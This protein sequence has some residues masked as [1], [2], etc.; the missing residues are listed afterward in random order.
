MTLVRFNQK[1]NPIHVMNEFFNNPF[2]DSLNSDFNTNVPAVNVIENENSFTIEL[3][4]PGFNKNDFEVSID[5]D[6][7]TISA[8]V[9]HEHEET[10]TKFTRRE[11]SLSSFKRSFKLPK[12]INNESIKAQY[13]NGILNLEIQKVKKVE[14]QK[15]LIEIV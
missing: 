15:R 13:V 3:A 12:D 5:N 9:E 4:A 14:P 6:T 7:L 10:T 1:S 2:F 11:F 8:K